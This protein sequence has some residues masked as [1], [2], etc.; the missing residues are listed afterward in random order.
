M[1]FTICI[2]D[3]HG[4]LEKLKKLWQN[5]ENRIGSAAFLSSTVIFLGDY[6]DRGP[7]ARGVLDFLISLPKLYPNQTHVFLAG[8]HDF[9]FM[10]LLGILPST[11]PGFSFSS[12]WTE[13][14][15]NEVRE[16][17]WSGQGQ[18]GV[19]VQGRRWGGHIKTKMNIKKGM[20][21][22]GSTYDAAP[23]FNSYGVAHGDREGR[24]QV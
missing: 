11:P 2:G 22:K 5:L 8:N 24:F 16:G 18:E 9:A 7:D 14:L 3:I 1:G 15:Q 4:H 13:Y 19:H 23:T 10:A 17:W 12:T 20:P 6:N 21:Y